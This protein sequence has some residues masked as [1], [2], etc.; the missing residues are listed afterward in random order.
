MG[1]WTSRKGECG[2]SAL[3]PEP[4]DDLSQELGDPTGEEPNGLIF[5][6]DNGILLNGLA[7][8][9]VPKPTVRGTIAL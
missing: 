5:I 6:T 4:L 7:A 2:A 8:A 9:V 1:S 3:V